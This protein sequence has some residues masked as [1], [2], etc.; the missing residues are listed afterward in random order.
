MLKCLEW[1]QK[2]PGDANS[3]R[4]LSEVS[5]FCKDHQFKLEKRKPSPSQGAS[6]PVWRMK[7]IKKKEA[8]PIPVPDEVEALAAT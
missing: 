4:I 3:P 6:I 1:V 2:N 7:P 5:Q 8:A